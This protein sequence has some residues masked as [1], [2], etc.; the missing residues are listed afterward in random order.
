MLAWNL[1]F[2][3]HDNAAK[4][5][6]QKRRRTHGQTGQHL[7]AFAV[8]FSENVVRWQERHGRNDGVRKEEYRL[9]RRRFAIR[10]LLLHL[11]QSPATRLARF[12]DV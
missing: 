5:K 12:A 2:S 10:R 8:V 4:I 9:P 11:G 1:K 6:E 3:T 7:S